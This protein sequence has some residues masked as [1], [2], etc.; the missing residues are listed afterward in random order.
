M[1]FIKE[2]E[3]YITNVIK[4]SGYEVDNVILES[5]SRRDLGEFQ[6]NVC[7]G[8]AKKYGKNPREIAESIISEFDDRFYNVNIAGPGF[9]NVSISDKYLLEYINSNIKDTTGFVDKGD[10]KTIIVDYGGANAAKVLHVGHMRPANIGESLKR[11]AELLGNKTI[12][13]VHLGDIGR[14]SG[15]IISEI[16]KR[17]P[18]LCYFDSEYKGEYPKLEISTEE[19]GEYYPAASVDAKENP[20]R[21]EE[22][23][24]ITALVDEGKEPYFSMWKDIV[25]VSKESIKKSYDYLNCNF[26]LWEGELS[27]LEYVPDTLKVL[28]PYM[29]ISDGA[30]VI[31]VKKDDDKID[32]PPLIVI[33]NDGAT[34]YA[35]RDLATIYSRVKKYNPDE[36]WYIVDARQAMYFE[37]VFRASYKSHL[38]RD[39]VKLAHYWFGTMNGSDGKPFKTRD[40][41][42][43][44]LDMLIDQVKEKLLAKLDKYTDEEKKNIADV[45]TVATIKYADLLPYRTTDFIFDIDK[46]TSFEGKTGPYVLYTMVR[47]K[48]IL[49]KVNIDNASIKSIY[50]ETERN[51][52]IKLLEL[53]KTLTKAYNE[54][55]LSYICEYLFDLCSLFNKFYGECNIINEKDM[56]KK[57]S[58]VALLNLLYNTGNMLLNILAI[59]IPDKM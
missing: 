46:I 40:G 16:K 48:S 18:D 23:R 38:V 5:S 9:I 39:D 53:A 47:I 6:I 36:I 45:L 42:V 14:Q 26:D 7:M 8:L 33:K 44:S 3:N 41:G 37:Q 17:K 50:S 59:E 56:S 34:I 55:T 22:V 15:M 11:L 52:Y 51:I 12:G 24:K 49:D 35:T 21:M 43:M 13:D 1:S 29:Y 31:D 4:K 19:L 28:E 57:E 25:E 27:S 10:E 58:Y 32:I 30:K 20:E 2:T 54:K